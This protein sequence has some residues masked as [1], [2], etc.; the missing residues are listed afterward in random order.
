MI[1]KSYFKLKSKGPTY[2]AVFPLTDPVLQE[3]P[4]TIER[5][6]SSMHTIFNLNSCCKCLEISG[7][8]SFFPTCYYLLLKMYIF[9]IICSSEYSDLNTLLVH[10][11]LSCC[12]LI[13]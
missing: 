5:K 1:L 7:D 11:F 13:N 9:R 3:L 2:S 12:S 10:R 4:W 6:Q 8:S